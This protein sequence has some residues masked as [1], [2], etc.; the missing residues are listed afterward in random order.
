MRALKALFLI[1]TNPRK[2]LARKRVLQ[3]EAFEGETYYEAVPTTAILTAIW[4]YSVLWSW[5]NPEKEPMTL[6]LTGQDETL[7]VVT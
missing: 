4:A 2:G 3:R 5:Q 6:A 7:F 1:W